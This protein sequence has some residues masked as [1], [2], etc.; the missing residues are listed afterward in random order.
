MAIILYGMSLRKKG[1]RRLI[2]DGTSYLWQVRENQDCK[3]L[4]IQ[5][6]DQGQSLIAGF[7]EWNYSFFE[8]VTITP[9]IIKIIIQHALRNG[10]QPTESG[11]SFYLS[12]SRETEEMLGLEP[13]SIYSE[14]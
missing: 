3:T 14:E 4:A 5:A 12:F 7:H 1:S 2:I 6:E 10:W 11:P 8:R 13:G 9:S